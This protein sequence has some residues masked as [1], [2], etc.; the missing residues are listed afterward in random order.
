MQEI[1]GRFYLT[2][3]SINPKSPNSYSFEDLPMHSEY[4]PLMRDICVKG[5]DAFLFLYSTT[6]RKSFDGNTQL[7]NSENRTE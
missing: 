7:Q 1:I 2:I 6:D 3:F 5:S 4:A